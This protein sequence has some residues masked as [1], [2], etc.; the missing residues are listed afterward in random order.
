[1]IVSKIVS[2]AEFTVK[3]LPHPQYSKAKMAVG[4][5]G[6]RRDVRDVESSD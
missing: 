6:P 4:Q 5:S 3:C 1:M 2:V